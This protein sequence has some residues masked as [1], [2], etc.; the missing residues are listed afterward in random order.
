MGA[1]FIFTFC[2][3]AH[4]RAGESLL[5]SKALADVLMGRAR[6]RIAKMPPADGE[7]WWDVT[8]EDW[9]DSLAGWLEEWVRLTWERG[10]QWRDTGDFVVDGKTYIIAGG[11]SCGDGFDSMDFITLVNHLGISED[12]IVLKEGDGT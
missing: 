8:E 5:S 7:Q 1:D 6:A 11:T 12:P 10:D 9:R 2:R 3:D 4:G